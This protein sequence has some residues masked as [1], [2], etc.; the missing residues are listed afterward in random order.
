MVVA[1]QRY[2]FG[3]DVFPETPVTFRYFREAATAF[4]HQDGTPYRVGE[5][6]TDRPID[7]DRTSLTWGIG[8][9]PTEIALS[10]DYQPILDFLSSVE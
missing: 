10:P 7:E 5:I 2:D 1:S 9:T 3:K 4:P 6:V 8:I